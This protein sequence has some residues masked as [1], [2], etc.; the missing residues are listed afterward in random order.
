MSNQA[1]LSVPVVANLQN[2]VALGLQWLLHS[3]YVFGLSDWCFLSRLLERLRQKFYRITLSPIPIPLP[4]FV[5]QFLRRFIRKCL[6]EGSRGQLWTLLLLVLLSSLVLLIRSRVSQRVR[7]YQN[8]I[9][10]CGLKTTFTTDTDC[11]RAIISRARCSNSSC[12][13]NTV[14]QQS[15]TTTS[16]NNT[17]W[18]CLNLLLYGLDSHFLQLVQSMQKIL[19]VP[20]QKQNLT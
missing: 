17:A 5:V 18:L 13:Q 11:S 20:M 12:L 10:S 2:G 16:D 6:P 14:K 3:T 9:V 4:S 7:H 1:Y 8:N 15:V 19:G